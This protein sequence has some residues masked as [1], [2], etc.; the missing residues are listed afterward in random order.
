MFSTEM[1]GSSTLLAS[2]LNC[3]LLWSLKH[4]LCFGFF[5]YAASKGKGVGDQM[6]EVL[7]VILPSLEVCLLV[8]IVSYSSYRGFL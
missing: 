3:I 8:C 2:L 6:K 5:L 4:C 1:N 7:D